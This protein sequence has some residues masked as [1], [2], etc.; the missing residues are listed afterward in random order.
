MSFEKNI[1]PVHQKLIVR[2]VVAETPTLSTFRLC[3]P[4]DSPLIPFKPGQ[5]L[6]VNVQIGK[7]HTR[8]AY[9]ICS[10]PALAEK[11]EYRISVENFP[12]SFVAD[13]IHKKFKP[14]FEADITAPFGENL[15]FEKGRDTDEIVCI[16]GGSGI[17]PFLSLARAVY[18]GLE[19]C[20]MTIIYGNETYDSAPYKDLLRELVRCGHVK[21]IYALSDEERPGCIHGFVDRNIIREYC[22]KDGFKDTFI[23]G[24]PAMY[25]FIDEELKAVELPHKYIHHGV[26]APPHDL[27]SQPDYEGN[28]D[29]EYTLTVMQGNSK[30]DIPCRANETL[31][32]ALERGGVVVKSNCRAGECGLCRSKIHGGEIYIPDAKAATLTY[33]VGI[34][35]IHPCYTF[36]MSDCVIEVPR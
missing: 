34:A 20:D 15:C 12:G 25:A 7:T 24:P 8:R 2:D 6:C 4:D 36:P 14:G 23:C 9:S 28:P 26:V 27:A 5:H 17:T 13:Y 16:A 33:E 1:N 18:G 22:I 35:C 21:V 30:F 11:G 3:S 29:A 19:S 10:S 32:V 31:L